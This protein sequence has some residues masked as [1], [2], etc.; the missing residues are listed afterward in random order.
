MVP[1]MVCVDGHVLH[2]ISAVFLLP[3]LSVLKAGSVPW[4][5]LVVW[6][7][8]MHAGSVPAVLSVLSAILV[9]GPVLWGRAGLGHRFMSILTCCG[10][11]QDCGNG[12]QSE[13]EYYGECSYHVLHLLCV[14]VL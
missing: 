7:V 11:R 13:D 6:A 8:F 9:S 2:A 10:C 12:N 1:E 14:H 5:G 3:V 4:G